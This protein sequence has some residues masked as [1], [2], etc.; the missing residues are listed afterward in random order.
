MTISTNRV[1][2]VNIASDPTSALVGTKMSI[3][4][5]MLDQAQNIQMNA[6]VTGTTTV[7]QTNDTIDLDN[8]GTFESLYVQRFNFPNSTFTLSNGTTIAGAVNFIKV[9]T[10]GVPSYYL[11]IPDSI[12]AQL[13][14]NNITSINPGG[15]MSTSANTAGDNFNDA[16]A[17]VLVCFAAETRILTKTGQRPIGTLAAGDLVW[18]KDQGFQPVKW[19]GWRRVAGRGRFAPI[20]FAKGAVG[21]HTTLRVSPQHRMHVKGPQLDLMFGSSEALVAAQH[22]VGK[23]GVTQQDCED[24]TYVHLMFDSH[25]VISAEGAL[26]ESYF[27]G[28]YSLHGQDAATQAELL[29]LFPELGRLRKTYAQ[30]C[31]PCLDRREARLLDL[32]ATTGH[33][34][35][36]TL[37][38]A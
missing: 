12:A 24:I 22:L 25:C 26:S 20:V 8:N 34:A 37:V 7:M 9:T 4:N 38:A 23:P 14:A 31:L 18:V 3:Y 10:G 13:D 28:E 2:Q 15:T 19:V 27:P 16:A 32:H 5:G 17:Y 33:A 29:S 6:G 1:I 35:A 36:Q 30:T 11:I 21:N